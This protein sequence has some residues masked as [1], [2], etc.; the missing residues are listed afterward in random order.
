MN[1]YAPSLLLEFIY[2]ASWWG[3]EQV[4]TFLPNHSRSICV[5]ELISWEL[6]FLQVIFHSSQV[7]LLDSWIDIRFNFCIAGSV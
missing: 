5:T 2:K 4:K 7:V 1:P 3:F 6:L